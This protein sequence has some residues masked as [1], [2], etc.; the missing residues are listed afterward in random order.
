MKKLNSIA[1]GVALAVGSL[2][3]S[4]GTFNGIV[5][6]SVSVEAA[7]TGVF[8]AN[9]AGDSIVLNPGTAYKAND[10]LTITVAGGAKFSDAAYTLEQSAGGAGTGNLA[11][12]V[13]T[14]A[15]TAG[16]TS[17]EFKATTDISAT[18]DY[19]LSGSSIAG[20]SVNFTMPV[21]AAGTEIDLSAS[22]RDVIGSYDPFTAIE[23]FQFANEFSGSVTLGADATIDVNKAR[24][25]FTIGVT[26]TITLLQN[27]NIT[28]TN[29]LALTD[30]DKLNITLSGD[31]SGIESITAKTGG[32]PVLGTI[33][34]AMGTAMFSLSASDAHIGF[35][36]FG[37]VALEIE[38]TTDDVLSTRD[39]TVSAD[40]DFAT[41][42]DKNII[43][44]GTDAGAWTIN[45]LQAKVSQLSL[46]A[47][48]FVSWLKIANDGEIPAEV[49]AD[50]IWTLADGTEGSVDGALLGTVD[51][52]GVGTV[53]EATILEAMGDP[54]QLADVHM[55]VTVT[56]QENVVHLIAEKKASDGRLSVPVYYNTA[57]GRNWLQ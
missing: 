8:T 50:I 12:F 43:A 44:A 31:M 30:D 45:G 37:A 47:S 23:L 7:T 10:R 14:T 57:S 15:T 42:T 3:A 36:G 55:T 54:T 32:S 33:D 27:R 22:A 35:G 20:Q 28:I 2:G 16:A 21:A 25:E 1:V 9:I 13:V 4:A 48:G 52:G 29:F 49:Y 46:N 41:E 38:V 26:D 5:S 17:I 40:L 39:F 6:E 34:E 51:A 56:G 53:S 11:D 18:D 24:K 19:I